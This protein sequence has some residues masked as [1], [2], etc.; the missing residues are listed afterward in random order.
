M[1][2]EDEI[3]KAAR[4][5]ADSYALQTAQ[6]RREEQPV[7]GAVEMALTGGRA[8]VQEDARRFLSPHLERFLERVA[9]DACAGGRYSDLPTKIMAMLLL[10][11]Q[12]KGDTTNVFLD[13]LGV[14]EGTARAAVEKVEAVKGLDRFQ[15]VMIAARFVGSELTKS[16]QWRNQI[17][18]ALGMSPVA[19][20]EQ[21]GLTIGG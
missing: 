2:P 10:G 12:E 21:P 6:A 18:E 8:L 5:I 19:A 11:Y 3:A 14:P 15:A 4:Q 17:L 13:R 20:Q 16:P 7:A 1:P 9:R